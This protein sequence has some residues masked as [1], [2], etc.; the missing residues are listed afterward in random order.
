[1]GRKNSTKK[2][3]N[4][5]LNQYP[6]VIQQGFATRKAYE[7][8]FGRVM[9][10]NSNSSDI[11]NHVLEQLIAADLV[12]Q[13]QDGSI[14]FKRLV[15]KQKAPKQ[16]QDPPT[17]QQKERKNH[18]CDLCKAK[19]HDEPSLWLHQSGRRHRAQEI[20][21]I[22][23]QKQPDIQKAKDGIEIPQISFQN[24]IQGSPMTVTVPITNNG[25][26]EIR[27]LGVFMSKNDQRFTTKDRYNASQRENRVVLPDGST[28]QIE[29][30]CNSSIVGPI[31]IFIVFQFDR[32]IIGRD[33][34][35]DV[36]PS[37]VNLQQIKKAL[38]PTEPYKRKRRIFGTEYPD[39][40][41]G[42]KPPQGTSTSRKLDA[43]LIPTQLFREISQIPIPE[44]LE[45][46]IREKLT[47]ENYGKKFSTYL[48]CEERQ[49]EIDIT[50]YDRISTMEKSKSG[51]TL[52][53]KVPGLAEKRPSVLYG[54]SLLAA[55][56]DDQLAYRGYVHACQLEEVFL[57]FSSKFHGKYISG[58]K[59][60]ISFRVNRSVLKKLHETIMLST[61]LKQPGLLFPSVKIPVDSGN[62]GKP[63]KLF[64]TKMNQRQIQAVS[65]I[66]ARAAIPHSEPSPYIIFGPPG[67]GKTSTV[68]ECILQ[69]TSLNPNAKILACTPSNSA[70]DVIAERLSTRLVSDLLR[71]NAY[72]REVNT[73]PKSILNFCTFSRN[74]GR[75]EL[76]AFSEIVKKKVV[77][78]TCVNA[79]NLSTIK[80]PGN[81]KDKSPLRNHFTHI[82]IDESGHATE[83]ECLVPIVNFINK[84][85]MV[86][87]AGDPKQLGPVI[88]SD[89]VKSQLEMSYLER[90]TFQHEIYE[91]NEIFRK[92]GNYNPAHIT[93]LV[94]NYRSHSQILK[95]PSD[96]F[97]NSE[98]IASGD[99]MLTN[100]FLGW[101]H[102]PN[103]KFPVIFNG[104]VGSETRESNSPSWFNVTEAIS[105]VNHVKEVL[106]F[107]KSKIKPEE[108]GIITPYRKQVEKIRKALQA[109]KI[110]NIK[111][112][113]V[114]E[115]QGQ[116]RR[117]ILIST[118]RSKEDPVQHDLKFNLGFLT[119]PK[120]FNVAI[121]RAQS[122]LIIVGNPFVLAKDP[123]WSQFIKYVI[124]NGGY[125]GVQFDFEFQD[126][127]D[128]ALI[129]AFGD[130]KLGGEISKQD[131]FSDDVPEIRISKKM[132]QE[133]PEWTFIDRD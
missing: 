19:F 123:Y 66:M 85:A 132:E 54:D 4:I 33:I 76:P 56:P 35:I 108:I 28:Y 13:G 91:P 6:D 98:L 121:T 102:L 133:D 77:V 30:T 115:F 61:L 37:D 119:N 86:I 130:L 60:N 11:S 125:T 45:K 34:S 73:V 36:L 92:F 72:T 59:V 7:L 39:V 74:S 99:E 75:F 88:R 47:W 65:S 22:L 3:K 90:L 62:F 57:K 71:V 103:R 26:R 67:T 46:F 89:F 58:Q 44:K 31:S 120:R 40:V 53:L 29:L 105:I 8:F 10:T 93:K 17:P 15:K 5:L 9:K 2:F 32:F 16:K 112:G 42:E 81:E 50:N 1:M 128:E 63:V 95:I 52:V 82:I 48:W 107:K 110:E 18:N 101:D 94:E 109:A 83:P 38:E 12:Q 117:V 64:N 114:E 68:I 131:N 97:Y 51:G 78:S 25:D 43:N 126:E 127:L 116:E 41:D 20:S 69:I 129:N 87:I 80:N 23:A 122:L 79:W 106:N 104:I 49:M 21:Q 100:M 70:A 96:L 113:S 124:D 55:F 84:D 27:F 111:V 14:R 24:V 118:V